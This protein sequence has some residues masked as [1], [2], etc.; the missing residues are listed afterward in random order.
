MSRLIRIVVVASSLMAMSCQH[1][2]YTTGPS[3]SPSPTDPPP[4]D[5]AWHHNFVFF[6]EREHT[7]LAK[8]CPNGFTSVEHQIGPLQAVIYVATPLFGWIALGLGEFTTLVW[9]PSEVKVTCVPSNNNQVPG[10]NNV[11]YPTS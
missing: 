2:K 5:A 8:E 11:P 6:V 9:Q 4:K 7:N 3:N 10:G 1:I